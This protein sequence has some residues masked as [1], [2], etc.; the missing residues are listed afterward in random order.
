[1][2]QGLSD[3]AH[4]DLSFRSV[5]QPQLEALPFINHNQCIGRSLPERISRIM[6]PAPDT[7]DYYL[8][9]G[10]EQTAAT[11]QITRS[12]RK[13]ALK[14]HPDRNPSPN[15][16]EI[17]Q[18]L[19]RAYETLKDESKRRAY[20]RI[21]PSLKR[22]PPSSQTAN[23]PRPPP[24][25]SEKPRPSPRNTE[26]PRS[27]PEPTSQSK[28]PIEKAQIAA[29]QKSKQERN[30]QWTIK[31]NHFDFL[32]IG[33]KK[34]IQRLKEEIRNLDNITAAEEAE[35]AKKNSWGTWLLSPLYKKPVAD[36]EEEK[37]RKERE[38]QERRLQKDMKERRL[39][40]KNSDLK[41][42]E[43]LLR[44]AKEEVDAANSVDDRKIEVYEAMIR[45][46]EMRERE[47]REKIEREIAARELRQQQARKERMEQRA[48]EAAE[49]LRKKQAEERA[50]ERKQAEAAAEARRKREAEERAAE[51]KRQME[52]QE[53]EL[54]RAKRAAEAR[55]KRQ[56]EEQAA[57]Q[58]RQVEHARKQST[59]RHYGWWP[60]VQGRMECP[61][62]SESW[63]YMLECPQCK[64]KACPKCQS[65]IRGR[66][67][68]NAASKN[69]RRPHSPDHTYDYY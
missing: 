14:L 5:V 41:K 9:L 60:K 65:E 33:L 6:V 1:M 57:E 64:M 19:G 7:E 10:V 2:F 68:H 58:K 42:E 24:Q 15:A 28:T 4:P 27:P 31:K 12:Y 62:C 22:N 39:D 23:P 21:Y 44:K 55:R 53:V 37:A 11:E 48:R 52:E 50:A 69:S 25:T 20:D 40:W 47:E 8:A 26:T 16:T 18:K 34:D 30:A 32:I 38:R 54:K 56:A 43:T 17:F 3:Y 13:L 66:R 67:R 63:P 29:L 59:C 61:N 36:S 45:A 35:E 46:R 49:A 51:Q